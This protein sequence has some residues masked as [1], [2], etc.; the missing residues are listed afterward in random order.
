MVHRPPAWVA[1]TAGVAVVAIV[2]VV[3]LRAD[4]SHE[5]RAA[6]SGAVTTSPPLSTSTSTGAR[7]SGTDATTAP[8]TRAADHPGEYAVDEIELTISDPDEE[9]RVVAVAVWYPDARGPF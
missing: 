7:G 3:A 5:A 8:V 9:D 6:N 1:A 4:D 2:A